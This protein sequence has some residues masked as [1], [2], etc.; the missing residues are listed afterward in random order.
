MP[1]NPVLFPQHSNSAP[2]FEVH[3]MTRSFL[4]LAAFSLAVAFGF[5][6]LHAQSPINL[7]RPLPPGH[8]VALNPNLHLQTQLSGHIPAWVA[9]GTPTAQ[10]V[11]LNAN[12]ELMILLQRDPAVEAAFTQLLTDQQT[13][14]NPLYH[15]WLT[16]QQVGTLFGPTASDLAAVTNWLT[17]QGLVVDQVQP[18]QVTIN[19][20]GTTSAISNAFH[21]NFGYFPLNGQSH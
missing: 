20:H 10:S 5:S 8:P 13:P 2:F 3:Q 18:N 12:M 21:T 1:S 15:Q 14:G 6:S 17:A 11:D 7:L 9:N 4:R 16:P 19:V